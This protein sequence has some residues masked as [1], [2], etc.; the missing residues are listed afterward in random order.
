M[1]NQDASNRWPRMGIR[2]PPKLREKLNQAATLEGRRIGQFCRMA[3]NAYSDFIIRKHE[4]F[5]E[6]QQERQGNETQVQ[7][8]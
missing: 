7:S 2:T 6:T 4:K 8:M 3:L 1:G 5:N